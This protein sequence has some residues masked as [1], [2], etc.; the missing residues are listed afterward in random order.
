MKKMQNYLQK[1]IDS[2]DLPGEALPG[3]TVL[4]LLGD[5]R[6]L[7]EKHKGIKAYSAESVLISVTFGLVAVHGEGLRLSRMSLQNLIITGTISGLELI[8]GTRL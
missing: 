1:F 2:M 3:N 5:G 7:I 8:R 4:E 6:I